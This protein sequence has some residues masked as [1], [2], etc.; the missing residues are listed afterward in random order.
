MITSQ[1]KHQIKELAYKTENE[2]C[3]IIS[4]NNLFPCQNISNN[5]KNH[6]ILSPLDYLKASYKGKI[7]YIYHSHPQNPEFS[8]I[9]KINLYNQKL[10]GVMY[11]K[12][13]NSF[14]YFVPESYN[15]KYVGR[16]FEIGVNDCLTLVSDYYKNELNI[17]LPKIDRTD[18]WYKRN[19]N[20]VNESV[21]PD[22]ERVSL[23]NAQ[24]GNIVVFDMLKNGMPQ[25]FGIYLGNDVLLHHP[26]NKL[27]TIEVMTDERKRK[28]PYILRWK[29]GINK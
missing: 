29:N 5:P 28:I 13:E 6:F 25:H 1:I 23:E 11:C 18:G 16:E 27:S 14:H 9:D 24:K 26:R 3:G 21:P 17:I 2:I 20:L 19:P 22:F 12:S 8:E 7:E 10:R 15:N 4:D